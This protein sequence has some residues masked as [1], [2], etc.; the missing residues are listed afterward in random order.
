MRLRDGGCPFEHGG[1]QVDFIG[2]VEVPSDSALTGVAT[3][4]FRCL[5]S[6]LASAGTLHKIPFVAAFE[7]KCVDAPWESYEGAQ[8]RVRYLLRL[9][10]LAVSSTNSKASHDRLLWFIPAMNNGEEGEGRKRMLPVSPVGP[11]PAPIRMDVGLGDAL[12]LE[13]SFSTNQLCIPV[14][15]PWFVSFAKT[16]ETDNDETGD[17]KT[18]DGIDDSQSVLTGWIRFL[19]VHVK[20]RSL[21]ISLVRKEFVHAGSERTLAEREV[22]SELLGRWQIMEGDVHAGTC[23]QIHFFYDFSVFS[24]HFR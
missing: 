23:T 13:F 19:R 17:A 14:S 8:V 5:R 3:T 6:P 24:Q 16:K 4:Q 2:L 1:I 11:L 22:S 20:A 9:S 15:N 12:H 18:E 10:V 7:F 21:E